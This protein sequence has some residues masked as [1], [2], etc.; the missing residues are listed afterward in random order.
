MS[1]INRVTIEGRLTRDAVVKYS[2]QGKQICELSI[3]YNTYRKEGEEWVQA[4]THFFDCVAWEAV[5]ETASKFKKGDPVYIEG[6][7]RQEQW[8]A[9][10]GTSRSRVKINVTEIR[11]AEWAT[12]GKAAGTGET[13]VEVAPKPAA[14]PAPAPTTAPASARKPN[15]PVDIF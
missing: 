2:P 7:L 8:K 4:S 3:A 14:A 6:Q 13:F 1:N 5:A 12:K 10:D 9:Q 15:E 11:L